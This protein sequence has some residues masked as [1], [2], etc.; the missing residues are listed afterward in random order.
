MVHYSFASKL[1]RQKVG[2]DSFD[3][4]H[5]GQNGF[6]GLPIYWVESE[7]EP[8]IEYPQYI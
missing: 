3:V 8:E 4:E 1:I 2:E 6:R 5:R 7:V